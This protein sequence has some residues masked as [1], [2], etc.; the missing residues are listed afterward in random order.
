MVLL[1]Y[2]K[3]WKSRGHLYKEYIQLLLPVC[4]LA[5]KQKHE[6]ETLAEETLGSVVGPVKVIKSYSRKIVKVF[7]F[8]SQQRHSFKQMCSSAIIHA[9]KGRC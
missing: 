1:N 7:F 6:E 8:T 4:Y 3:E 5:C 9:P 2:L